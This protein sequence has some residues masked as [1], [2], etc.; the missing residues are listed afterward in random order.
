MFQ[1]QFK[2]MIFLLYFC[3]ICRKFS[4]VLHRFWKNC[5][6]DE[7]RYKLGTLKHLVGE[8]LWL[9]LTKPQMLIAGL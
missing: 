5:G 4:I 7:Q 8:R 6:Y 1:K 2:K 9:R 3:S